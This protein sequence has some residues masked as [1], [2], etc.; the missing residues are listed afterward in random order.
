MLAN[1]T[2]SIKNMDGVVWLQ[3]ILHAS[4]AFPLPFSLL[5]GIWS[6]GM[7]KKHLTVPEG[8]KKQNN[9][10]EVEDSWKFEKI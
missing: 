9:P 4:S 1:N 10:L 6:D 5:T 7:Q 2:E 3:F 8:Y